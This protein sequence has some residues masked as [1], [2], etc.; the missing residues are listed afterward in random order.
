ME[1]AV[2]KRAPPARRAAP[3]QTLCRNLSRALCR[4]G[5]A[6]PGVRS[7]SATDHRP[8]PRCER[9]P[10]ARGPA[11]GV[12][13]PGRRYRH[14][15]VTG[16]PPAARA[17]HEPP[18]RRAES[19]GAVSVGA[20]PG[21]AHVRAARPRPPG[22]R[23]RPRPGLHPGLRGAAATPGPR[24]S[25]HPSVSVHAPPV[26]AAVMLALSA[27]TLV[28]VPQVSFPRVSARPV[29]VLCSSAHPDSDVVSVSPA[30]VSHDGP[31]APSPPERCPPPPVVPFRASS[32]GAPPE[33]RSP[34]SPPT[35]AGVPTSLLAASSL[36]PL[37]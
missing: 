20:S 35:I 10:P 34:I 23:L 2:G 21:R 37:C 6:W 29:S 8:P 14:F 15:G 32:I 22:L 5:S 26:A 16:A 12:R 27:P 4:Q 33:A 30:S 18:A 7:V 13:A 3:E 36:T 25:V 24:G 31:P 11:P 9:E 19:V 1:P 28:S 17:G